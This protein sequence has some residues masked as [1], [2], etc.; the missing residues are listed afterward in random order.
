MNTT[1]IHNRCRRGGFSMTEMVV[2]IGVA[3]V[4]MVGGVQI[5]SL[6]NRQCRAVECRRVASLEAGNIMEQLMARPWEEL[7]PGQESFGTLSDVCQRLLPDASLDID[8]S[9]ETTDAAARR[10][11]VRID[12]QVQGTHRSNPVR[13]VAWRY[14]NQETLP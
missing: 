14:P 1:C 11:T 2:T 4:A 13:L 10:I 12:W 5:M 3:T 6:A 8:V 9:A 7:T